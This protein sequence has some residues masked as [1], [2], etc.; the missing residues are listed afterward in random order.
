MPAGRRGWGP[1]EAVCKSC[2]LVLMAAGVALAVDGYANR[3]YAPPPAPP[4]VT[5]PASGKIR[6][7]VPAMRRSTPVRL[8]VPSIGVEAPIEPMGRMPDGT[9]EVPPAYRPDLTGW[10]DEGVTPGERGPATL[11]GH[12]DTTTDG[13]AVFYR[14]GE[15]RP[16]ARVRVTREDGSVAVFAITTVRMYAK[17][18]FPAR[19]VYGPTDAPTLRLVTCGGR[20]DPSR[21]EYLDNVVAFADFTRE[22]RTARVTP[23]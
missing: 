15:L 14:L 17:D 2:A 20:F 23:G 16:G 21:G 12:V 11:L 4:S 22:V 6:K 10:F 9:V 1:G 8:A 18:D 3:D 19:R 13:P 5:E 7:A